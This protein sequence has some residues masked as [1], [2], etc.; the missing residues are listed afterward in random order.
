MKV[1]IG[2]RS[3]EDSTFDTCGS[4]ASCEGDHRQEDDVK[5]FVRQCSTKDSTLIAV[6]DAKVTM[7]E[8]M[9]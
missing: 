3:T 5:V 4:W 7:G 2:Q 1:V 6:A 9:T 8:R